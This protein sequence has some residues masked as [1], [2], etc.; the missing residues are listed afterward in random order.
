MTR[1]I[2]SLAASLW[3]AGAAGAQGELADEMAVRDVIKDYVEGWR[4]GNVERLS[5]IFAQQHGH[6][7]WR[8][9]EGAIA[10][11]TFGEALKGRKPNPGYGEP[12]II[13][14]IDIVDGALAVVRFNVERKGRGSYIDYFTLY[15]AADGWKIV[16]KAWV[17]RPGILL[18]ER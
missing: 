11:V 5:R 4:D 12:Y 9:S 3:L 6:I 15:K 13:E 18:D 16:T 17:S 7:I 1:F 14:D 8:D 10:S 2:V